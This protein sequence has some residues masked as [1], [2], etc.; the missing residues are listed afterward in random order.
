M[1]V[2]RYDI[3]MLTC[4]VAGLCMMVYMA[5]GWYLGMYGV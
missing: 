4:S 2:G 5:D 3:A 1:Q